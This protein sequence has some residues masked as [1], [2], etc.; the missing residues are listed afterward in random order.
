[1]NMNV[2]PRKSGCANLDSATRPV[3]S[4]FVTTGSDP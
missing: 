2:C 1:M 3:T 4:P